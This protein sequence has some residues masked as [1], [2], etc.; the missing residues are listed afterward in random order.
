MVL[1]TEVW[2]DF[3]DFQK[4]IQYREDGLSHLADDMRLPCV[5]SMTFGCPS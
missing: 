2:M 4:M 3:L 5:P 1:V